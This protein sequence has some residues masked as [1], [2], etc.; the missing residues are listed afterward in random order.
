[1]PHSTVFETKLGAE[2]QT[3]FFDRH[4][5]LPIVLLLLF[6]LA[7]QAPFWL[8]GLSTDPIWFYSSIVTGAHGVPGS[9]YL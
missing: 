8:L 2:S 5:L 3:E 9:P 4:P 1:M 7:V 6:P